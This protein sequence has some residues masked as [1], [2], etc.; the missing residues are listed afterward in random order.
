M[1]KFLLNFF[2]CLAYFGVII[3]MMWGKS[4]GDIAAVFFLLIFSL[5]HFIVVGISILKTRGH[6]NYFSLIGLTCGLVCFFI[7]FQLLQEY[8][9]KKH[10]KEGGDRVII[11]SY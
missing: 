8:R 5:V 7:I 1:Q 4:G 3:L 11:E 2:V 9:L 10:E 6:K